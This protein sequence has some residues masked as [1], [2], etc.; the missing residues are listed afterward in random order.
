[1]IHDEFLLI[2]DEHNAEQTLE[3]VLKIITQPPKWALDMPL[4]GEG[5]ISKRYRK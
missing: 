1:L 2:A 4:A 5:W 3:D